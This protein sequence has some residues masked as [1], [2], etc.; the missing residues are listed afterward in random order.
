MGPRGAARNAAQ[1]PTAIPPIAMRL[2]NLSRV[3]GQRS[4]KE[5]SEENVPLPTGSMESGI[6]PIAFI[7]F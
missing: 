3:G 6:L 7:L 1:W 5:G 4:P 2:K